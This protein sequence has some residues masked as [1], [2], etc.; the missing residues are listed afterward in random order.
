M[1]FNSIIKYSIFYMKTNVAIGGT[2]GI[3][4]SSRDFRNFYKIEVNKCNGIIDIGALNFFSLIYSP[5]YYV[6]AIIIGIS[7]FTF[8]PIKL[9]ND[10][11]YNYDDYSIYN[12]KKFK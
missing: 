9:V 1:L 8:H 5:L 4:F 6:G 11:I 10:I 3:A 12:L 2:V 7:R